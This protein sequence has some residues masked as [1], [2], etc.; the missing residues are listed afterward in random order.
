MVVRMN[1]VNWFA[2]LSARNIDGLTRLELFSLSKVKK[3]VND[4]N[5]SFAVG[6]NMGRKSKEEIR[7]H[8]DSL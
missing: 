3:L 4:P 5:F 7:Q 1:K 6:S 2:G 8:I